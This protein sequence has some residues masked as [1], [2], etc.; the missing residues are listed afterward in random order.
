MSRFPAFS[1]LVDLIRPDVS[2]APSRLHRM[3]LS[4]LAG[5]VALGAVAAACQPEAAVEEDVIKP[6]RTVWV[7]PAT[8]AGERTI[9]LTGVIRAR[10]DA[11]IAF[12]VGGKISERVVDVGDRVK[13]GDA[14]AILD[15]L[16]LEAAL[17]AREAEVRAARAQSRRAAED[18]TRIA[19]LRDKGHVSQASL[20]QAVALDDAAAASLKAAAEQRIL[21]ANQL[22]YARLE[23]GG[24]GV[25]TRV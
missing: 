9:S 14:I 19:S 12:R 5:V 21:A 16:D 15:T 25:V 2:D 24:E 4:R 8:P 20:D 23:A 7:E 6:A 10:S 22:A 1:S 11:P 17:R 18:R 3:S 13:P